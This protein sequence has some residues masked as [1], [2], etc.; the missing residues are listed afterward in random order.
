MSVDA[1]VAKLTA[2]WDEGDDAFWAWRDAVSPLFEIAGNGREASASR[3][4]RLTL[5]SMGQTVLGLCESGGHRFR[6]DGGA[7]ARGGLDQVLVQLLLEGE[8]E[9]LSGAEESACRQG[10]IRVADLSRPIE[11]A[12]G[13]YRNLTLIIPRELVEPTRAVENRIHGLVLRREAP[14]TRL[15]AEHMRGVLAV[16]DDLTPQAA[17]AIAPASVSLFSACVA[18]V[19]IQAR[20]GDPALPGHLAAIRSYIDRSLGSADLSV[21]AIGRRFGLSRSSV[22]RLFEPH[23][24]VAGYV[25]RQ[26][27]QRAWRRLTEPG[28]K[29]LRIAAVGR[30][31][32]F[33]DPAAF[34]RAFRDAYGLTPRD[35]QLA[36]GPGPAGGTL[37]SWLARV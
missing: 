35:A 30:D 10:D 27:L 21:E 5:W 17:G 34:S 11:T 23:G 16:A 24:G 26:R 8:D 22:Y 29:S 28:G 1:G 9:V 25:R 3:E 13:R 20:C 14:A 18:A 2:G 36:S 7:I 15:L 37:K 32:G 4:G 6:R 31:C 33:P 19:G 12:T